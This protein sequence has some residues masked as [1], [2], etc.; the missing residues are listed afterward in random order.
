MK[1]PKSMKRGVEIAVVLTLLIRRE[2]K[3]A[4]PGSR[5]SDEKRPTWWVKEMKRGICSSDLKVEGKAANRRK[6][7]GMEGYEVC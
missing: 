2:W 5:R 7:N 4:A 1:A 6:I 3:T